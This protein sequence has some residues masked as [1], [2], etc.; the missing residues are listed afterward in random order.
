MRVWRLCKRK[1]ADSAFDGVGA[2]K[3]GG[4]WNSA[5][6]AVAYASATLALA[7]L[8]LLVHVSTEDAP[9]NLVAIWAEVPDD[10][11]GEPIAVEDMPEGWRNVTGNAQVIARGDAWL[12][13]GPSAV[14]VVP[15]VIIR[16]EHNVL[17]NPEHPDFARVEVGDTRPFSYDSRLFA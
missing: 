15:S 12:D 4:R 8:E 5:G 13:S 1:Y 2:K 17:L 10:L 14:L 16:E 9:A 7:A 11:V 3:V 6:R